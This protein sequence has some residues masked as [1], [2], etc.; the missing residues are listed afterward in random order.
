[1]YRNYKVDIKGHK[2]REKQPISFSASLFMNY[3]K[4]IFGEL[5]LQGEMTL[6]VGSDC[7]GD[8]ENLLDG[9]LMFL[10][11]HLALSTGLSLFLVNR[12]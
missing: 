4:N 5:S 10:F 6:A 2:T 1:M 12:P 7:G 8:K 3:I 9:K 11:S